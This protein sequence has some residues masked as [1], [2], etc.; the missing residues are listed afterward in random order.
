[1][2]LLLTQSI[3][4]D[5]MERMGDGKIETTAAELP[6]F[7]YESGTIYDPDDEAMGLFRGFL[8]VRVCATL[9]PL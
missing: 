5:F 6:S 1:V 7:L 8:V 4:S 3:S 2:I 9:L